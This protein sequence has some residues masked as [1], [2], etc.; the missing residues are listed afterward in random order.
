[1]HRATP[2]QLGIL[3]EVDEISLKV[4]GWP[5]SFL[6]GLGGGVGAC[7]YLNW[8]CDNNSAKVKHA[9]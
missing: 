6:G 3:G 2:V 4:L 9:D 7:K 1:L 8:P 5:F